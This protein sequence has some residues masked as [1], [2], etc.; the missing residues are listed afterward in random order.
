MIKTYYTNIDNISF[1]ESNIK[2]ISPERQ[3]KISKLL[4]ETPKKQCLVAG[5]LL[6][7]FFP[8]KEVKISK[9][10][11]PYIENDFQFNI[12]HSN[13]YVIISV[14]NNE[15]VGCDI[16]QIGD[17]DYLKLGKVVFHKE[18]IESLKNS[19][20][21]KETFFDLWTKKEAFLK[22]LGT[23][24]HLKSKTIDLSQNK[25]YVV[26]ENQKYRF[27]EYMLDGY[28][29][30]LCSPSAQFAQEIKEITF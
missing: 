8:D 22:C 29:I 30:M 6:Q 11:K 15:P 13:K 10:G 20:N 16:E 19:P 1:T 21:Q 9:Y 2:K 14:S 28:K 24:F 27:K 4:Q 18:E 17:Y 7:K 25:H 5:L 26:Y 12:A 3:K 23:G